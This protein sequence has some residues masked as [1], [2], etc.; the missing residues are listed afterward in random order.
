MIY[1]L[2]QAIDGKLNGIISADVYD[3]VPQNSAYP[4]VVIGDTTTNVSDT[5]TEDGYSALTTIYT[6]TSEDT[7]RGYEEVAGIMDEIYNA[8]HHTNLTVSGYGVSVIYQEFSDLQR[9]SDGITRQGTQR[10]RILFE[11]LGA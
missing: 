5:D 11:K 10:F 2:Q 9:D 8:L 4:L 6:W 7:L 1:G 3:H